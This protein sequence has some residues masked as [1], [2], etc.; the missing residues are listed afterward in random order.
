MKLL[1][2]G[3]FLTI[4]NIGVWVF[5]RKNPSYW[6]VFPRCIVALIVA[7]LLYYAV[8]LLL[9]VVLARSLLWWS[10]LL[11]NIYLLFSWYYSGGMFVSEWSDIPEEFK[12]P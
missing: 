7:T 4:L 12:K 8:I 3:T 2:I 9:D 1:Q 11:I 10:A 6:L 5:I